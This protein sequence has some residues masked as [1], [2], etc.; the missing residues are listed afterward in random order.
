MIEL[1]ILFVLAAGAAQGI[2]AL[3]VAK[4]IDWTNREWPDV[5]YRRAVERLSAIDRSDGR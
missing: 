4:P 2:V 3:I 1:I 5:E